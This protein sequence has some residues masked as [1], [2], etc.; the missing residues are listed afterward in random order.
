M[1]FVTSLQPVDWVGIGQRFASISANFSHHGTKPVYALLEP[2]GRFAGADLAGDLRR[3]ISDRDTGRLRAASARAAAAAVRYHLDLARGKFDRPRSAV[4]DVLEAEAIYGAFATYLREADPAAYRVLGVAWLE[5]STALGAPSA[6]DDA[7]RAFA[8]PARTIER[9]L[10]ANFEDRAPEFATGSSAWLPPDADLAEQA[11]LPRLV[12]NFERRGIDERKL[13]LVAYGDM[14]FDSPEIYGVPA[15]SL[16]ITCAGCHNRGD[17]NRRFFIPGLSV[18]RGGLDVDSGFFN[19][20]ANDHRLDPVDI[21]S[22]RGI[23]FTAPYGR[24]GRTAGLR[25]FVRNVVVTEFAGPEPT[26]LMLDALI[27]Y[28]N[29]FDFLPVPA[30]ERDGRLRP[31]ASVAA[32]RGEVLFNRRFARMSGRSCASCHIPSANFL[33]GRR[34]EIGSGKPASEFARDSAFDTPTLLGAAYTAPYFHDGSLA[35]LAAVVQWFDG[36]FGLGLTGR[37]KSDLVAY[38]ETAGGGERPYESF[39]D[40]ATRFRMTVDELSTFLSALDTLIPARDRFH[41][42][43]LIG[44]VARDLRADAGGMW[45]IRNLPRAH[46]LADDLDRLGRAVAVADWN[47]AARLWRRYKEKE[48]RYDSELY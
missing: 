35:T 28:L 48:K 46:Q 4:R 14:L 10:K 32:R 47:E 36:R 38:L 16:G 43:L 17:V 8:T 13:F 3:A 20:R 26:P 21:P 39:D 1:I 27:A 6:D 37:E 5:L 11:P 44:T 7:R 15:R 24:N 30:L 12:L 22:L 41:A 42:E 29:E 45:N 34:H 33:D 40:N 9:Y 18:R 23:R 2:V 19:P 25:N 31:D